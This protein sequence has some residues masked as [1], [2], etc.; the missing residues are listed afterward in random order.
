MLIFTEFYLK[1]V[2]ISTLVM[3]L[4]SNQAF[5]TVVLYNLVLGLFTESA[6]MA[7]VS[8]LPMMVPIF[9]F[10]W[11][12][13]PLIKHQRDSWINLMT[14]TIVF[15]MLISC[16]IIFCGLSSS[17]LSIPSIFPAKISNLDQTFGFLTS[18]FVLP[19]LQIAE[20]TRDYSQTLSDSP[21]RSAQSYSLFV[22]YTGVA[23]LVFGLLVCLTLTG[24]G[25]LVIDPFQM[26]MVCIFTIASVSSKMT[27]YLY[28]FTQSHLVSILLPCAVSAVQVISSGSDIN[29]IN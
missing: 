6:T 22:K 23:R 11:V 21:E 5:T 26:F 8:I 29:T 27:A 1:F 20:D 19:L 15:L 7:N 2:A 4:A 17:E 16:S 28:K 18:F 25:I 9:L 14:K 3:L 24:S 12:F 10:I 13:V